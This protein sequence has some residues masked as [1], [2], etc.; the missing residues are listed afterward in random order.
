MANPPYSGTVII[1]RESTG[2]MVAKAYTW[3]EFIAA[4]AANMQPG[5]KVGGEIP[6]SPVGFA[7]TLADASPTRY[8]EEMCATRAILKTKLSALV[9]LIF[10]ESP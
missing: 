6:P 9:D 10:G 7:S 4:T 5:Q 3:E 2:G 1:I 8:F